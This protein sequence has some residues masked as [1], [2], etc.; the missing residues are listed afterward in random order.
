[1][2][3]G[4]KIKNII[5]YTAMGLLTILLLVSVY[6]GNQD[7]E[8]DQAGEEENESTEEVRQYS[9][10][11]DQN[12]QG[13]AD[14]ESEETGPSPEELEQM[15]EGE[16]WE[17]HDEDYEIEE[18]EVDESELPPSYEEE[19]GEEAV[20]ESK[21]VVTEFIEIIHNVDGDDPM[22]HIEDSKD[23]MTESLYNRL[24]EDFEQGQMAWTYGV[25]QE[26]ESAD[27]Y[28]PATARVKDGIVWA[29]NVEG[30]I[31]IH[32]NEESERTDVYL[33]HLKEVDGEYKVD[34]YLINVPT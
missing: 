16:I 32:D 9:S 13:D 6:V 15:G 5:I 10:A 20:K 22:K 31:Q 18:Q 3:D 1:M 8:E 33:I 27:I 25:K 2:V 21:K 11:D 17:E 24:Q 28:E 4:K 14:N 29:V 19:Y 34:D 26:F 7:S 12:N 30:T 23:F